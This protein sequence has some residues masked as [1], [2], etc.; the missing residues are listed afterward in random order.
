MSRPRLNDSEQMTIEEF[1]AFTQERPDGERWELIEGIAILNASP[2]D[3]HQTITGNI[4]GLLWLH[5][6]QRH[7]TWIPLLGVGTRV[8]VSPGS[9]PQPDLMVKGSPLTGAP[10]SDEAL[11][12]FEILSKSN[13][14]SDQAWRKRVYA[15]IPNCQHYVTVAQ[16]MPLVTRFDRASDW[17]ESESTRITETLELPALGVSLPLSEIYRGTPV[18]TPPG[19]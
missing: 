8:P 5:Q 4:H 12:L 11:V 7:V 15:S 10:I 19:A 18:A 17:V 1:L 9:L 14:K 13:T 6:R 16:S 3:Y 2:T